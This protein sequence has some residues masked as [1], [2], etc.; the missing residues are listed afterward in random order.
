MNPER[1]NQVDKLLQS[2]L[3]RPEAERDVF[4]RSAC[5]DDAQLEHDVRSL[6][7]AHERADSFLAAPAIELAAHQLTAGGGGDDRKG[8][9][10]PLIGQTLSHYRTAEKLG[11]G[12]MGVVYRAEDTRLERSVALKFLAPDLADDPAALARFR[13]EARAASALNHANICTVYD[14]GEQDGR[15]FLV[16][17]FLDGTTLKHRIAGRPLEIDLLL[18]L[19]I[20]IADALEAAHTA[21]IV[22]RDIKP[23]NLF[24]TSRGHAKIL[25]FGLAKV[26]SIGGGNATAATLTALADLTSPGSVLGT[27]AYMSPEQVRAE[28]VDA[29]TDLFSFGTVLYEMATGTMPFHGNSQGLIFDA[30]LNR[31]P[32]SAVRLNPA[33]PQ[34]LERIIDTCLEKDRERRYQDASAIRA[35]LERLK[36]D[37]DSG[38]TNRRLDALEVCIAPRVAAIFRRAPKLTDKDTIVLADFDNKT[39]DPVFDDTLRQGLSVELQQSPFLSLISDRQVQQQLALM[40]Q[41]KEARL[42]SDVARQICERTAST[43]VLEGSIARLGSQYVL[44]LRARNCNTGDVLHQEQIQAARIEDVLNSLS[45]IARKLRTRLGESRA[46]VE[47]HSTPLAD[48][49]TPSLEALKAYSTALKVALTDSYPASIPFYRRAIEIDP[50]FAMAHANLGLIYSATGESVLSAQSAT[51]AWELRHR[52]SD[53]ERF[54]IDFSYDRHVTGNLEKAYRT[55]ESWLRT[56][57]RGAPPD[58]QGLLGGLSTHGTGRYER[59]IEMSLAKIAADPDFMLAY[60]NLA[61]SYFFLDRFAEAES[62]LQQASKRKIEEQNVLVMHYTIAVLKGDQGQM[63]RVV[64][65]A[66]GKHGTEHRVAHAEALALARSGRLQAARQSSSRAIELALQEGR[67]EEAASYRAAR[68]V[69]TAVYGNT[70]EGREG[71]LAALEQSTGRDVQYAAGLALGLAGDFSRSEALAADLEARFPEDTFVK[72]TYAPVLRSVA[73]LGRDKPADSVTRL[74][75]AFP[76]ELAVNGLNFIHFYLGGL[77]SAYV[78]GEA[79]AAA[80]RYAEAAAE[81]QKI[82]DHRGIVGADP[83]GALAH[84]QLGRT[85]ASLGDPAK[86]KAAYQDFLTLW[87]DADSDVPILKQAMAEYAQL[88]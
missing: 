7:A 16:M 45:E 43:M 66:K 14:I 52:V 24:V 31:T 42:T 53:R 44:G 50:Q 47:K 61:F 26:R 27:V 40:G 4:L 82:R 11:G 17:E 81:F 80:H 13:R 86:A 25:D 41:P 9:R 15:A 19:A 20:E 37:R 22:H 58:A 54:F 87:N 62:T 33:L 83:I 39:G 71:A 55:L 18:A 63:D 60:D 28:D 46:T 3:E 70:A 57:P 21:G 38:R 29:R 75:V 34:E 65:L 72:F 12:G 49:T 73:A 2:A 85:L 6:L 5:G 77:H 59:A 69:W 51:K 78:R 8:G 68:A 74:Q 35:D 76:Y 30:I 79:L 84:L 64:A 23:A 32:A 88:A 48:A 1:W 56:Y 10:D 36:R 67:R